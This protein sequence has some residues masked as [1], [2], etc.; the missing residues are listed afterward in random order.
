MD[1]GK[2]GQARSSQ[3]SQSAQ[4][5]RHEPHS[6]LRYDDGPICVR[7]KSVWAQGGGGEEDRGWGCQ[8]RVKWKH[9]KNASRLTDQSHSSTPADTLEAPGCLHRH[10]RALPFAI[11]ILCPCLPTVFNSW[12]ISV[13]AASPFANI[14]HCG[15]GTAISPT[16]YSTG[17]ALHSTITTR[18]K[19]LTLNSNGKYGR[20]TVNDRVI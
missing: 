20:H 6:D 10:T 3:P 13:S 14:H 7:L 15:P 18:Q 11:N 17:S 12:K 2:E 1:W 4:G 5:R 8:P 16:T 9:Q 19:K